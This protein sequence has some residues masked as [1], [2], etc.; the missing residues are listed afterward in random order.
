MRQATLALTC[1]FAGSQFF[2]SDFSGLLPT[3]GPACFVL[4]VL[5]GMLLL[6]LALTGISLTSERK[7]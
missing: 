2:A 6:G 3:P 4:Y 7:R 5:L 1:L